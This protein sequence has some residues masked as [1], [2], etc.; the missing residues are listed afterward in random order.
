MNEKYKTFVLS[1][2]IPQL[3]RHDYIIACLF[4]CNVNRLILN[5]LKKMCNSEKLVS[6]FIM[7]GE[8]QNSIPNYFHT[9]F[10][11]QAFLLVDFSL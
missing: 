1:H 7:R 3:K 11:N 6:I 8:L 9:Y 4:F 2:F 5:S 10:E